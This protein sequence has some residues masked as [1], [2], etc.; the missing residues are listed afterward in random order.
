MPSVRSI[1]IIELQ[2]DFLLKYIFNKSS[3][4]TKYFSNTVMS[5]DINTVICV[6]RVL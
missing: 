2:G 1:H 5:T 6:T 4:M 3:V